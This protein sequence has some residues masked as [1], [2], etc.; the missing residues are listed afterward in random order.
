MVPGTRG[1]II[2]G[3]WGWRRPRLMNSIRSNFDVGARIPTGTTRDK[4]TVSRVRW[5]R[6]PRLRTRHDW[7]CD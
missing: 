2:A 5:A 4:R 1:W 3:G 6:W 7:D